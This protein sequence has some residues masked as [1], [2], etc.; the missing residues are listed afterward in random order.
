MNLPFTNDTSMIG[1]EHSMKAELQFLY[2]TASKAYDSE[3][4]SYN[5]V[6][7]STKH[8]APLKF[9]YTVMENLEAFGVL[10]F[11][12]WD[13]GGNGETG[14][15]DL[16]LG[17]KLG[18]L[19]EG[20]FTIRGAL[21]IPVGDGEKNLGEPGG[22]GLDGGVMSQMLLGDINLNGQAGVRYNFEDGDTK[23]Q[24][25]IGI[26]VDGEGSFALTEAVDIQAGLE[27]MF[28]GDGKYD[29]N[30]VSMTDM[31]WIELNVGGKYMF[32]ENIGLKGDILYNLS[33][34]NTDQYTGLLM[35]LGYGF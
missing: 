7:D 22:F 34:K 31:N 11:E 4:E 8:Y 24:P 2:T 18:V 12:K 30:T 28:I 26:Y 27:I 13:S 16:W 32:T 19:P 3:S 1:E 17:L 23:W 9:R 25:G 5:L 33:G 29:G 14:V 20:A 6:K 10:P 15:G 35:T 21:D